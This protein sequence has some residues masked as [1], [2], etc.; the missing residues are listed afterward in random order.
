M[1]NRGRVS[2]RDGGVYVVDQL[3][4][5]LSGQGLRAESRWPTPAW[6][7]FHRCS[8]RWVGCSTGVLLLS[9]GYAT[10]FAG[11]PTRGVNLA[12]LGAESENM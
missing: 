1:G 12:G 5:N 2:A 3:D 10:A 9:L 11:G 8:W 7:G 4:Y 6:H